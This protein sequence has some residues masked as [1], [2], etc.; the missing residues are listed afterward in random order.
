MRFSVVRPAIHTKVTCYFCGVEFAGYRIQLSTSSPNYNHKDIILSNC[1][2][3]LVRIG[4]ALQQEYPYRPF[5]ENKIENEPGMDIVA[6]GKR[7]LFDI[8]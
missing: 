8:S 3:C 6:P 2:R 5:S 4:Y 1:P 7:K